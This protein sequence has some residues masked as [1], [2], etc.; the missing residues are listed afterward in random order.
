M[1][2]A[3]GCSYTA[4]MGLHTTQAYPHLMDYENLAKP[5]CDIEYCLWRAH[6][7]VEHGATRILFQ[8]TSWDRITLSRE[9]RDNFVNNTSWS[10]PPRIEHYT[11]AD[12]VASE[13]DS[14]IQ[15][16][17]DE[18]VMSNWRTEN[19]AQRL[20][21]FRTWAAWNECEVVYYDWLQRHKGTIMHPKLKELLP[22]KSVLDWLGQDH[23][24]D[25]YY[26]VNAQGHK[27]IAEGYFD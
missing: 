6:Q 16:I 21:E 2:V 24:L 19:L 4:G 5:G 14:H 22:A 27:L 9:G 25:K 10:G 1:H 11:V 26:H 12:Y 20:V 17:Y 23:Y 13:P 15:W 3:I 7:A 8:L 18:H